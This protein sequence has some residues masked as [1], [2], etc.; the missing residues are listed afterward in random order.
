MATSQVS[1]A[2]AT[3]NGEEF[4][5]EQLASIAEQT[6]P[7]SEL[8]VCDDGS[9]DGTVDIVEAF[10]RESSFPVHLHANETTRGVGETFMRAARLAT[11]RLIAFS[12]QDDVW[13]PEKL[14]RTAA[15]FGTDGVVLAIHECRVVDA[16]LNPV[17]RKAPHIQVAEVVPPLST[18]P[19]REEPGMAMLFSRELL[20]QLDW[21]AR[22]RAHHAGRLLHDEWIYGVARLCGHIAFLPDRLLLYRQ[23][24]R[25]TDGA[26]ERGFSVQLHHLVHVGWEYYGRRADQA[27]DWAD[28]LENAAPRCEDA[29]LRK[30][31]LREAAAWRARAQTLELRAR[32]HA[33]GISRGGRAAR[34]AHAARGGAYRSRR[35]GGSG[36]RGFSRDVALGIIAGGR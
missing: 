1:V 27:V 5:A 19:W 36:I 26:R 10:R 21:D 12:D 16:E 24:S 33:P 28:L 23:H 20:N 11:G 35:E 29:T 17:P 8:V 18:H 34:V 30:R 6:A 14:E 15:A 2:M 25:N 4:L 32:V 22:P 31:Y 3:F 7:P 9:D 13:R